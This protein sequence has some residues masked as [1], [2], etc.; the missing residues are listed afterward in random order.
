MATVRSTASRSL[1]ERRYAMS[2]VPVD[3]QLNVL[4]AIGLDPRAPLTQALVAVCNRYGLDPILKQAYII[5]DQVYI[6]HAGLLHVAH[7][8][9]DLDGIEV[10]VTEEG[11]RF[12]ATAKI[13]R[14]S[15]SR[16]FVYTDTCF[17]NENKVPDQRNRA[18]TRAERNAL[19]RAFDVI[20]TQDDYEEPRVRMSAESPPLPG[21][22]GAG[23]PQ[24]TTSAPSG[25]AQSPAPFDFRPAVILCR[26]MEFPEDLR[27]ELVRHIT[28]LRTQSVKE[29]TPD[30]F[31]VLM[32][33]L[34][35]LKQGVIPNDLPEVLHEW[36]VKWLTERGSQTKK[37]ESS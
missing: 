14:K 21:E 7:V 30:E 11:D 20:D 19:R 6:S 8:S 35:G 3:Q 33:H 26:E 24:G 22:I 10:E 13:Y 37:P 9:G 15:M 18:I 23:E 25:E 29:M 17:K 32:D 5:R 16:P 36:V 4:K 27:H 1:R 31:T 34:R 2:M 28:D 12:T